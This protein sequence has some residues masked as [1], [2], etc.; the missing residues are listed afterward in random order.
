MPES[1]RKQ[2]SGATLIEALLAIAILGIAIVPV[3]SMIMG[4]V[5]MIDAS[6]ETTL[7]QLCVQARMEE[8]H[9]LDFVS[10][11]SVTDYCDLACDCQSSSST[12]KSIPRVLTVTPSPPGYDS[13][14]KAVEVSM[15]HITM[16]TLRAK[17]VN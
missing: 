7:L 1:H 6:Q 2:I 13:K 15:E 3:S 4:S 16:E 12:S 5:Q 9:A 14:M 11:S 10:L 17:L 8:I